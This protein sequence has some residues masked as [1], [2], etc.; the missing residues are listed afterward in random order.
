MDASVLSIITKDF[1][2]NLQDLNDLFD[3]SYLNK[4][5]EIFSKISSKLVCKFKIETPKNIFIDGFFCLRS[6][7]HSFNC[8]TDNQ[9]ILKKVSKCQSNKV[10]LKVFIIVYLKENIQ[11]M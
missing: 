4:G 3:F 7:A 9:N 10:N 1:N 8:G 5:H 6:K 2:E 11:K